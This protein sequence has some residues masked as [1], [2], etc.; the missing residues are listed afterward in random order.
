L[1]LKYFVLER[2]WWIQKLKRFFD[3]TEIWYITI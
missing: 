2:T 1:A 3:F